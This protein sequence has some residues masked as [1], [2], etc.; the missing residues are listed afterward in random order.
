MKK[1]MPPNSE[2][3]H[4]NFH[5]EI[6]EFDEQQA[7]DCQAARVPTLGRRDNTPQT[8]TTAVKTALEVPEEMVRYAQL[9]GAKHDDISDEW[10][11][12]GEAP[13]EFFN[14]LPK[15]DRTL[16]RTPDP[17]C[18]RC[19]AHMLKRV[20]RNGEF[21]KC[22]AVRRKDCLGRISLEEHLDA[23]PNS[24][25]RHVADIYF[26]TENKKSK[27]RTGNPTQAEPISPQLRQAIEAVLELSQAVLSRN[28]I[29]WLTTVKVGLG[30]RKPIDL[31]TTVGG[32]QSVIALLN[33]LADEVYAKK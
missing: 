5:K 32:Y 22:S 4:G 3:Q 7:A 24:L 29:E 15:P 30:Y 10:F 6:I 21:W 33:K 11:V 26:Q 27:D 14:L 1:S 31:M 23:L 19:G 2:N 9:H 18:P 13:S 17:F 25:P 20:D 8:S 12:W 28:P 16:H